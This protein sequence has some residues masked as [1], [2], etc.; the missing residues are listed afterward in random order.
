MGVGAVGAMIDVIEKGDVEA[1]KAV[2]VCCACVF[3]AVSTLGHVRVW[4]RLNVF[5]AWR[6]TGITGPAGGVH[7][8]V[9]YV[10]LAGV[11]H[12]FGGPP[13]FVSR[14]APV[15]CLHNR[16]LLVFARPC[17]PPS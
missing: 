6:L 8:R 3:I 4:C 17:V 12:G 10:Q 5:C 16:Q 1:K 9:T 11:A 13:P 14:P 15:C 2:L 7:C